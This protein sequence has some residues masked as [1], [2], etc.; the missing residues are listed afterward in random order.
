MDF[1]QIQSQTTLNFDVFVKNSLV[2]SLEIR[3]S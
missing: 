3:G 1:F 2:R